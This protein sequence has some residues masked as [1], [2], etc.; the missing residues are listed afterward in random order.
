MYFVPRLF[1]R[2]HFLSLPSPMVE[3]NGNAADLKAGFLQILSELKSDLFL[4]PSFS[5]AEDSSLWIDRDGDF[6]LIKHCS[7]Q[8]KSIW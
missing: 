2:L 4:H 7:S 8:D 1:T 3:A 5:F 6:D